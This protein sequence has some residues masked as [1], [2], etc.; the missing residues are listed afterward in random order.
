MK[1]LQMNAVNET[2]YKTGVFI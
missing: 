2:F 1:F